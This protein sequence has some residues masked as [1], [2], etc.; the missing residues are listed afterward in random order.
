M[1]EDLVEAVHVLQRLGLDVGALGEIFGCEL[2]GDLLRNVGT[3]S[4]VQLEVVWGS[5]NDV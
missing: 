4:E 5:H 2:Q 3:R 1:F